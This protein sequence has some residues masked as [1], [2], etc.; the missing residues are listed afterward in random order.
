[1]IRYTYIIYIWTSHKQLKWCNKKIKLFIKTRMRVERVK[2]NLNISPAMFWERSS[3]SICR[4]VILGSNRTL[5]TSS[6]KSFEHTILNFTHTLF[7]LHLH[8]S[9][10]LY[11]LVTFIRRE[12]QRPKFFLVQNRFCYLESL[13]LMLLVALWMNWQGTSQSWL[14]PH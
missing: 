8:I 4:Q 3:F 5:S 11:A 14:C 6:C 10:S 7:Y 13:F 12:C 2:M 1:M 9:N